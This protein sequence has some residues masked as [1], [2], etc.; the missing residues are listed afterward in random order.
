MPSLGDYT[1]LRN[2][3]ATDIQAAWADVTK[4]YFGKPLAPKSGL[5]YCVVD[6]ANPE[7]EMLTVRGAVQ[8]YDFTIFV[9]EAKLSE[10]ILDQAIER[11]NLLAPILEANEVYA[12]VGMN[13]LV[14]K[15]DLDL[16]S[17]TDGYLVS[18]LHFRVQV[19]RDWGS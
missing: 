16:E 2:Q 6:L 9:V 4:I 19:R 1:V 3:L 15:F 13:P 7:A 11:Q 5:P 18:A 12:T 17:E 8:T 10:N 14:Y